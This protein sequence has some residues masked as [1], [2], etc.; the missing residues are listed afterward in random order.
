MSTWKNTKNELIVIGSGAAGMM[1]ALYAAREGVRPLLI[2]KNEK[3]GKKLYITGKGRCNLTNDCTQDEFLAE[4]ADNPRFLYSALRLLSPQDMMALIEEAGCPVK[5]ERGRRVFPVSDKASDV[6]K[7]L[8]KALE[9]AGFN[10]MY[11]TE[12]E[13]LA[14][15]NGQVTGVRLAGGQVIP[16]GAV[17]VATGGLSYPSTGSTGDG[18]RFAR[19]AGHDIVPLRPSLIPLI[20]REKWPASLMGL[21]LLNVKLSAR[22]KG[23][24]LFSETGEM[25]FTHFGISGPLVLTLSCH[26]RGIPP[27]QLEVRIDLKPALSPEQVDARLVRE[28]AANGK[29]QLRT[30]IEALLPKKMAAI[31]P[32]ICGIDGEKTASQLT[33]AERKTLA[34][35]LKALPLTVTG[36]RPVEEA[37]VTG[38]GVDT[39]QVNPSTMASRLVPNLFFAGEVLDVSAHTG[40][41]NLQIAFSTGAL[42]GKSAARLINHR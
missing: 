35:Y 29:K 25:L 22:F 3:P 2:E 13:A 5:V 23:K 24:E 41:Y 14:L 36:T 16:A 8:Q 33:A 38:G 4:V 39:R 19:Q 28:F 26:L 7:A 31:F 30:V 10:V 1:A 11:R 15:E 17:I 37:V 9:S 40:G 12:A 32:D 34:G 42:A 20:T 6:T 18:Y 27:E 21:S